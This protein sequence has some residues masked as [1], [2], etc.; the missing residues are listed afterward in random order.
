MKVP[1]AAS[2]IFLPIGSWVAR[3]LGRLGCD[4]AGVAAAG[5]VDQGGGVVGEQGVGAAGQAQG[6]GV[7]SCGFRWVSWV[8]WRIAG[9]CVGPGRP[10]R[11]V[12]CGGAGQEAFRARLAESGVTMATVT[13]P[14]E[15]SEA[16]FQ[17]LR[18][19]PYAR[20]GDVPAGRVWNVPARSPIFTGRDEL[21]TALRAAL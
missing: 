5:L 1:I 18:D 21:L 3:G 20:W 13:R 11:R 15:L 9:R 14:E 19:L 16:L 4:G 2:R 8:A 7:G 12:S 17:G 10:G 6:G